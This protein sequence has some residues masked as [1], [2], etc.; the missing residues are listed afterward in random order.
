[1]KKIEIDKDRKQV[2]LHLKP[3]KKGVKGGIVGG[4]NAIVVEKVNNKKGIE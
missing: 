3:Q 4:N 2:V 1:M